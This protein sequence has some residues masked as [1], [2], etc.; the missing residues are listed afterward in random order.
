MKRLKA[1]LHLH[2]NFSDGKL[3]VAELV[4]YHGSR[5]FDVIAITDHVTEKRQLIGRVTRHMNL[6][7]CEES[8]DRYLAEIRK[9]KIRA[10][11]Q[12]N[13]N[14]IFG[15]EITKNSFLN[16]RSCHLLIL[17]V[18]E[19]I[20][21]DLNVEE[22]LKRT[23]ELNGIAIAAHP[24]HT[25]EFEFQSFYLWSRRESL[26]PLIDAWEVS[27]RK[28]MSPDVL[29]SGLPL[30]ASSDLHHLGHYESWKSWLTCENDFLSIKQCL[31]N[32]RV[33]FFM[34]QH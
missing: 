28:K 16:H 14:L 18:E 11:E 8:F 15:Y 31:K 19:L 5:G 26:Q 3:S 20:S 25:G 23:Q 33:D 10:L 1:D 2:S 9:Q 27:N 32:R 13:M 22:I 12:Y 29:A 17:G 4:D 21:P 34:D 6:S 24:F 7:L 30:I